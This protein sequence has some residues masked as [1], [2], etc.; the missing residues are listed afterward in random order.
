MRTRY[1]WSAAVAMACVGLAACD[2]S[3]M[4]PAL[5]TETAP[6]VRLSIS[7]DPSQARETCGEIRVTAT[8]MRAN[9]P[10][11]SIV[12]N[13]VPLAG[14][15][16]AAAVAT[17]KDGTATTY[18]N[19]GRIFERTTRLIAR[20]VDEDGNRVLDDTLEVE[21]RQKPSRFVEQ[22]ILLTVPDPNAEFRRVLLGSVQLQDQCSDPIPGALVTSEYSGPVASVDPASITF[23]TFTFD[24]PD[25][26]RWGEAIVG[27]RF[28]TDA[29]LP[30]TGYRIVW[31]SVEV[32]SVTVTQYYW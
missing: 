5:P 10:V 19:L 7:T 25:E 28:S 27:Y 24:F 31:H 1:G 20:A 4:S 30:S 9:K 14:S 12:V 15:V 2:R 32:P 29:V 3:P 17:N 11:R 6:A 18:W 22:M 13:F 23:R 16:F 8:A 26:Q 21:K